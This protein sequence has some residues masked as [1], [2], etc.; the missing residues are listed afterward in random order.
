MSDETR[1]LLMRML[2]LC[3]VAAGGW[4]LLVKPLHRR[5]DALEAELR[6]ALDEVSK[7]EVIINA[8]PRDP[9]YVLASLENN[10]EAY[11]RWWTGPNP[12]ARMYDAV[13][14]IARASSVQLTGVEPGRS[15]T[16]II[17]EGDQE[18]DTLLRIESS[19]IDATGSF[20]QMIR[21]IQ[22]I[23]ADLGAV[24]IESFHLGPYDGSGTL[25]I[26]ATVT[27]FYIEHAFRMTNRQ[28]V[29]P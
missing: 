6:A 25:H 1:T 23:G 3:A 11:E 28:E 20:E 2:L 24:R 9:Q 5:A 7:G 17:G 27:R 13:R 26:Q 22:R 4:H 29:S 18:N 16:R 21:F 8:A 12:K 14:E 19:T 15:Q 10:A